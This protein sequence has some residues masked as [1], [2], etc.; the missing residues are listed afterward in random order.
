MPKRN[1]TEESVKRL[2]P[3]QQGK[4][5]DY[6]DGVQPGLVL[7]V[8]YGGAKV[9]RALHYLKRIAPDGKRITIP[10]TFKLGRYPTLSV[11]QAREKARQF[12]A[13]PSKG[14]A[15]AEVGSFG[16]IAEQWLNRYVEPNKLRTAP[17]RKR[18]LTQY[19]YPEWRD[20]KFLE[21]RRREV[22]N[23]LDYVADKHG[24]SQ[25]DAVLSVIRGVMAWHQT[26]DDNYTSP[27]VRGMVRNKNGKARSRILTHEEIR[28]VWNACDQLGKYGALIKILL[29]TAQRREK[30]ATMR[31]DD[32]TDGVWTIASEEREK[33]NAGVLKL[34]QI[35]VEIINAQPRLA[36]NPYVFGFRRGQPFTAWSHWKAQLDALL[37]DLGEPF[38]IHDLRRTARSLLAEIGVADHVAEQVLGH[39]IRGVQGIYNRHAYGDEKADALARLAA[40]VE[41][42][43]HPPAGDNVVAA[44]GRFSGDARRT[45]RKRTARQSAG[46]ALP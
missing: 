23:L 18:I 17:E 13:D 38:V 6:F 40:L 14:Y 27:I 32:L 36:G 16:E 10:T 19:I 5:A 33:G 37:P 15:L 24:L 11:K 26:R 31:W 21:I 9:W 30:V 29:L 12:L 7:R 45:G 8:N 41:R 2:R 46:A 22:N 28:V 42:I 3:P 35:A 1:L 43:V 34:P 44:A 25:A 4:Q 39:S 20:R